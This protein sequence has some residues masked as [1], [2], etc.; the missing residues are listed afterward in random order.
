MFLCLLAIVCVF[1]YNKLAVYNIDKQTLKISNVPIKNLPPHSSANN[2]AKNISNSA[3]TNQGSSQTVNAP[4]Q[5][6]STSSQWSSSQSKAITLKVPIE[7][8]TLA[9]GDIL[10]G[11]SYL[12]EIGYL[13]IDNVSGVISRGKINTNSGSFAAKIFFKNSSNSGRL[14][15]F[16]S[17]SNGKEVNLIEIEVKF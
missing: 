3:S 16:S 11:S 1:S 4:S 13:L 8:G 10:S 14:D 5:I 7:N 9:S 6:S 12:G 17:D 15:V 2:G